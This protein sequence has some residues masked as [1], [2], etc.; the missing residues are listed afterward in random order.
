M[1]DAHLDTEAFAELEEIMEDEFSTLLETYLQ[2][3]ES[4]LSLMSEALNAGDANSLRELSHSFKG[5]SCNIGALP[6]SRLCEDVEQLARTDQIAD[7]SP[8]MPR[9]LDEYQEVKKLLQ[10]KI[11]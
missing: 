5:A 9:I 2:D 7:I 8:L 4:K 10:Q 6:L 1:R 11:L 3:A